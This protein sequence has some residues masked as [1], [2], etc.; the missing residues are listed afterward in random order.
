M[1]KLLHNDSKT[2]FQYRFL[3]S[4]STF[5]VHSTCSVHFAGTVAVRQGTLYMILCHIHRVSIMLWDP[6]TEGLALGPYP[7]CLEPS[8][9]LSV[10]CQ[11][12]LRA[13]IF[14]LSVFTSLELGTDIE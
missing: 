4:I 12:P 6:C 8:L 9:L 7:G 11:Y 1:S 3:I 5:D 13:S 14:Q 10:G 2:Q